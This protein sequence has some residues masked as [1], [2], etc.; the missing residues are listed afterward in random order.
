M[1]LII[2]RFQNSSP[3]DPMLKNE[4]RQVWKCIIMCLISRGS[5][6]N[7]LSTQSQMTPSRMQQTKPLQAVTCRFPVLHE[8]QAQILKK[9]RLNINGV[10]MWTQDMFAV[11]NP[12]KELFSEENK[13]PRTLIGARKVSGST[14]YKQIKTVWICVVLCLF[15]H[16]R[17][18]QWR[19]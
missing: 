5:K 16:K 4:F 3:S 11:H 9:L 17:I 6:I 15:S 12:I 1:F 2:G 19:F 14:K 8:K 7:I 18:S 13:V 10:T